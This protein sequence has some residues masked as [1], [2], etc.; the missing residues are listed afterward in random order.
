M[1][2]SDNHECPSCHEINV[3]PNDLIPNRFLRISVGKFK[4]ESGYQNNLQKSNESKSSTI[5]SEAMKSE[6]IE[7]ND[8][9]DQ[10]AERKESSDGPDANDTHTESFTA[11]NSN[12]SN[13]NLDQSG[14]DVH[15][16]EEHK[17]ETIEN[18]DDFGG[19]S[20]DPSGENKSVELN[21]IPKSEINS[22]NMMEDKSVLIAEN[23]DKKSATL[24][25]RFAFLNSLICTLICFL[26]NFSVSSRWCLH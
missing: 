9:A 19:D 18:S 5:E 15:I 26:C 4:N 7:E 16:D 20:R 22:D 1:L 13:K 14:S 6:P 23:E 8:V 10:S 11:E 2:E 25:K 21:S 17:E 12:Q 24:A 3:S